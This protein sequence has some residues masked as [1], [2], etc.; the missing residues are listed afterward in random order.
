MLRR[1]GCT[2]TDNRNPKAGENRRDRREIGFLSSLTASDQP[3]IMAAFHQGFS[4]TG[5][6]ENRNVAIEYRWTEGQYD[7]LPALAA[8]LVR[9]QASVIAANQISVEAAKAATG[10]IP[11]V[12]TTALDPVKLGLVASLDRPGGNLTGITTRVPVRRA[13]RAAVAGPAAA[14]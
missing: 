13:R 1:P 5:Y 9:R 4:E 14:I 3:P 2:S 6:V 12:F 11:I 8:D 10:T 7:R